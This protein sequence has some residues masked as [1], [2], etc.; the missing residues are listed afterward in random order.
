LLDHS[1]ES[2][3]QLL[4]PRDELLFGLFIL[5]QI[6]EFNGKLVKIVNEILNNLLFFVLSL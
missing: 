4:H 3:T 1:P 5:P 6:W 2:A